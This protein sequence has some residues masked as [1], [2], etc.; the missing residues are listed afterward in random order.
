[1]TFTVVLISVLAATQ[2]DANIAFKLSP[3]QIDAAHRSQLDPTPAV[4]ELNPITQPPT[5]WFK[6]I[7][8]RLMRRGMEETWS[9]K[10]VLGLVSTGAILLYST[11]IMLA[12]Y[13]LSCDV[14]RLSV[15]STCCRAAPASS[16]ENYV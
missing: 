3:N 7:L 8:E 11:T 4:Y 9:V 14:Q 1:M 10:D 13:K 16:D 12:V 5:H 6:E 15:R 2:A